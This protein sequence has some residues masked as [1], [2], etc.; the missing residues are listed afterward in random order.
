MVG[1]GHRPLAHH[2]TNRKDD[3][4]V[5]FETRGLVVVADTPGDMALADAPKVGRRA[6]GGRQQDL[7][8]CEIS[9]FGDGDEAIHIG[10]QHLGKRRELHQLCAQVAQ[11]AAGR[12][13]A[14][15]GLHVCTR[16][17]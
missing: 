7:A 15:L 5:V 17:W 12:L 4:H 2:G 3:T 14:G 9:L 16:C 8:R 11:Q 10:R 6:A 1:G 13:A